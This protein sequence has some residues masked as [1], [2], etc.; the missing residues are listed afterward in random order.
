M[1][2]Y[3]FIYA[4]LHVFIV[5]MIDLCCSKLAPDIG[6]A[7]HALLLES[8]F[9]ELGERERENM[10]AHEHTSTNNSDAHICR[11]KT[12]HEVPVPVARSERRGRKIVEHKHIACCTRSQ[13]ADGDVEETCRSK[14]RERI[15]QIQ[16]NSEKRE[17]EIEIEIQ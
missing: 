13:M 8:F 5:L 17:I 14:E 6:A 12:K 11:S 3:E 7:F 16:N 10:I 15:G 9:I 1:I 2:H 4:S